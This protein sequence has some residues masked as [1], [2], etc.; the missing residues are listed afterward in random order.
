MVKNMAFGDSPD[1]A[2]LRNAWQQFCQQ[3]QTAGERVFKDYNPATPLHRADAFR[4][5]TQNLGQAFDLALETKDAKYPQLHA[6]CGPNR[7][8]GGDAA[9]L[10]YLQAWIDGESIYKISG[11]KGSARF[12]NFT[13]Q[14]PRPEKQPGGDVPSLHEP[15]GDI[16]EANLFGHQLHAEADGSFELFIGGP[17]REKNW[18][19]TTPGS[20]KL[21][22]RQGF[23]RWDEIPARMHIERVDMNTPRPLP[24][25]R[26]MIAAM[27]WA[28]QFV[29]GLM[30]DWPDHPYRYSPVVDPL[31]VNRFPGDSSADAAD[32]K[33]GRAVAHL[34]WQIAR[35]EALI[36]EFDSHDGFWMVSNNGV[37][38]NS[39]DFLYRPV[40][41]TPSRARVD[42]DNKV[43][44]ILCGE[45]PGYHNWL[46]TQGF[47]RGNLTYRNL[48]STAATTFNTQL[49]KR[50]DLARVL[51]AN[52]AKVTPEQ[53][54]QQLHERFD[55][56]RRRYSF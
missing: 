53:R 55:S 29:A 7:K 2:A 48:L 36:V 35:D 16:P 5:L 15:F 6:F 27:E 39:M 22:I 44:L 9:D 46:D 47:E 41:Y 23:D 1:D 3:L 18:L 21:F 33:R 38:F 4:F 24:T 31:N 25:P 11:N 37:F 12:L 17:Q 43:R 13:V 19:P 32:N 56:I 51:P 50:D 14:G 52:A 34:C 42:S 8:L 40:S 10:V 20:R 26:T 30:N 28:G 54:A 49:V 45:D